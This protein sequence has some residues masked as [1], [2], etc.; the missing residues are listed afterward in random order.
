MYAFARAAPPRDALFIVPPGLDAFRFFARRGIY[1]DW[2]LFPTPVPA[3]LPLWRHR[4]DEVAAPDTHTLQARGWPAV[5]LWD[6][7]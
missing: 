4:L 1:V 5:P 2:R 6:E 3:L 7:S